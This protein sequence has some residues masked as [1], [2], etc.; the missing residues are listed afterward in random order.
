LA[1][2]EP[3]LSLQYSSQGTKRDRRQG[4]SLQG[5][6]M[7][8]KCPRTKQQDGS[9][10][11][12][13]MDADPTP[14]SGNTSDG[15]CLDGERLFE[16]GGATYFLEKKDSAR[17]R[18]FPSDNHYEV[19]TKANEIRYYGFDGQHARVVGNGLDAQNNPTTATAIWAL[20]RVADA[21]GISSTSTTT[22]TG[23]TSPRPACAHRDRL[24]RPHE[25][26]RRRRRSAVRVRSN[27]TTKPAPT[28]AGCGSRSRSSRSTSAS[29]G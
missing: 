25:R 19:K 9:A 23:P 18:I 15:V 14:T 1:G 4:W 6:S 20:E 27:S 3:N 22:W 13:T 16:L 11:P 10:R 12:I 24:H 7:I 29:R 8:H 5:L 17:S 2:V 28:C 26:Q 21:W